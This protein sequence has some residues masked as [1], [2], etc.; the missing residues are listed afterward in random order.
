MRWTRSQSMTRMAVF[1][2]VGLFMGACGA[3]SAALPEG[4]QDWF[5]IPEG[6]GIVS[7]AVD[8]EAKKFTFEF[9]DWSYDVLV[10]NIRQELASHG[11]PIADESDMAGY[12]WLFTVGRG[13][14]VDTVSVIV[15]GVST[16]DD[17]TR[18][19]VDFH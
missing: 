11:L 6:G 13:R 19:I 9:T 1:T 16:G 7:T 5:P 14:G 3:G 10:S 15:R 4:F 12:G 17:A 18:M 8:R 2:L